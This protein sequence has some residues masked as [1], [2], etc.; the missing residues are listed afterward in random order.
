MGIQD[1]GLARIQD[2]GL[3]GFQDASL[4]GMPLVGGVQSDSSNHMQPH[5]SNSFMQNPLPSVLP[6]AQ[7]PFYQPSVSCQP[8]PPLNLT[9]G[10]TNTIHY[11]SS[12]FFDNS[13]HPLPSLADSQLTPGPLQTTEFPSNRLALHSH[14]TLFSRY[15]SATSLDNVNLDKELPDLGQLN[16][17]LFSDASYNHNI[18]HGFCSPSNELSNSQSPITSTTNTLKSSFDIDRKRPGCLDVLPNSKQLKLLS[19]IPTPCSQELDNGLNIFSGQTTPRSSV[20]TSTSS[21]TP[22]SFGVP[23]IGA[24]TMPD[25]FSFKPNCDALDLINAASSSCS[26]SENNYWGNF[27]G[28]DPAMTTEDLLN[29]SNIKPFVTNQGEQVKQKKFDALDLLT[30][31][32]ENK[33]DSLTSPNP[34]NQLGSKDNISYSDSLVAGSPFRMAKSSESFPVETVLNGDSYNPDDDNEVFEYK[35]DD[36]PVAGDTDQSNQDLESQQSTQEST[37][38]TSD[39]SP[40]KVRNSILSSTDGQ[41]FPRSRFYS[42]HC[43]DLPTPLSISSHLS[44]SSPLESSQ[45]NGR[46]SP[47]TVIIPSDVV[48]KEYMKHDPLLPPSPPPPTDKEID[49]HPDVPIIEVHKS[50]YI[51]LHNSCVHFRHHQWKRH[52][53]RNFTIVRLILTYQY[54]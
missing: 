29:D 27:D 44:C 9:N 24:H 35:S 36:L 5:A 52:C 12:Q 48:N 13:Y 40:I 34:D 19:G 39:S 33:N 6:P 49:L 20:S 15:S 54:V 8:G 50:F 37:E 26:S 42:S 28:F 16:S 21:G 22:D 1:P 32:T 53:P 41:L 25:H 4:N 30:S 11:G 38:S 45:V 17:P 14:N 43:S 23:C 47:V 46:I 51:K 31:L 10:S 7:V 18:A 3:M 2:P